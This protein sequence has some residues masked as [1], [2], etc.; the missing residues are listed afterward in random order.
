MSSQ[1]YKDLRKE[2]NSYT[3]RTM[4]RETLSDKCCNCGSDTNVEYH[5][6]VPLKLGGTNSIGN[7]VPLCHACHM[8]AHKGQHM[9]HYS[10]YTESKAGRKPK[11]PDEEGFKALD[12]LADG[13]I[14]IR[15]CAEMMGLSGSCLPIQTAQYKRWLNDR[16]IAKCHNHLD[17]SIT[18]N[19]ERMYKECDVPVG[20]VEYADGTNKTIFFNDTGL[21]DSIAYKCTSDKSLDGKA[22]AEMKKVFD[23]KRLYAVW[24]NIRRSAV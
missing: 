20:H 10:D 22:W 18:K 7:I 21:N 23:R 17:V 4:L 19:P 2:Y 8:A 3:F 5:H 12:L 9:S 15:K 11:V 1:N 16:G 14:G 13:R 6:I 24:K